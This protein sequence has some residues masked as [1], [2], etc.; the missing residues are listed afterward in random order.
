MSLYCS[1]P[2]ADLHC[3]LLSFLSLNPKHSPYDTEVRCAIPQLQQ[4]NVKLQTM[5]ITSLTEP[6]SSTR[7]WRQAEIFKTLPQQYPE[8]FEHLR[9]AK[10]LHQLTSSKTIIIVPAIENASAICDESEDLETALKTFTSWQRKIGKML[11]VCFTWNTENRFGGGCSTPI[12]LK[13]DGRRLLDYLCEKGIPVDFS[14]ASDKLAEDILNHLDKQN[15]PHPVLA[16]HSNMRAIVNV[17]RNLPNDLVKEILRRNGVIGLN[18][19]RH[20]I[21]DDSPN[22]FVKHLEHLLLLK[23][24]NQT[25]FGADF[26]WTEELPVEYR[27]PLGSFFPDYGHAGTYPKVIDMWQKHLPLTEETVAGICYD[28]LVKFITAKIH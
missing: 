11:Y 26:Y 13:N 3:D 24:H 6:G 20:F 5:A 14:H 8:I 19:I 16:S 2:I 23:G 22:N 12:G 15:I 18:F 7:G 21:G 9:S 25:C 17:P 27:R 28:N 10:Q 4:G 1:Q